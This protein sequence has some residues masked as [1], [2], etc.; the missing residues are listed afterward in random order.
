MAVALL[1]RSVTIAFNW[2]TAPVSSGAI[3]VQGDEPA[4]GRG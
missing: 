3:F 2:Q 1:F 4:P